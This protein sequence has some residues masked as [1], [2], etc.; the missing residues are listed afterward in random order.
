MRMGDF[1]DMTDI[2]LAAIGGGGGALAGS[3][4]GGLF[5]LIF[6]RGK[7]DKPNMVAIALTAGLAVAGGR[8]A[9]DLME[10]YIGPS[11][12]SILG[13]G[14]ADEFDR[15]IGSA[16]EA[17]PFFAVVLEHS[18]DRA[19][20]WRQ[21][22]SDAF[23]SGGEAEA[24]R[25]AREQGELIGA[26][27]VTE[28]LPRAADDVVLGFYETMLD[29]L[30]GPLS[31]RPATCYAYLY[32]V[33]VPGAAEGL[34]ELEQ[35]GDLLPVLEAMSRLPE[36]A[37]AEPPVYDIMAVNA[38]QSEALQA[39]LD[40]LGEGNEALFGQRIPANEAEFAL[41]C[42]AMEA[43]FRSVMASEDPAT[44]L[45]ALVAAGG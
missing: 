34:A 17:E 1:M 45:R 41:T 6:M 32:G 30:S 33:D 28:F 26:W 37:F 8:L 40:E 4:L 7:G 42:S 13:E 18:P 19:E 38:V 36:G 25:V 39:A 9:P 29:L 11:L 44:T 23:R 22:V 20:A 3:L 12:R 21:A 2:A 5:G 14:A 27:M 35:N 10:P 24:N 31:E 15:A 16:M 43:F